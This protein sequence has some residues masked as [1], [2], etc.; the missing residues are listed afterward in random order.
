ML[1]PAVKVARA[2]G[3]PSGPSGGLLSPL[4]ISV[5]SLSI[6]PS[7]PLMSSLQLPRS[8]CLASVSSCCNSLMP[9]ERSFYLWLTAEILIHGGK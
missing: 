1:L 8:R 5:S 7:A 9:L 6:R 2:V 4:F 3:K